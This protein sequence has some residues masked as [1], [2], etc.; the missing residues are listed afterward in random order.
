MLTALEALS[1]APEQFTPELPH[2]LGLRSIYWQL[3]C[4]RSPTTSCATSWRGCGAMAVTIEDG[5]LSDAEAALRAAQEALRQALERG[6]T[7]EEIKK[8]TDELRAALDKF[9]Q[10]LAEQMRK[11]PQQLARP[12][13]PQHPHAAA[14]G[15]QE[16][17]RPARAA[18]ALGRQGR[19]A[20]GCSK[21]CSRCWKTCRWRGPA[22]RA[23]TTW[24][25]T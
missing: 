4:A 1:I 24:T 25:T 13:D 14:A 7:D 17:D 19:G 6:A 21:S 12:L 23:A 10:A 20:S 9:M 2:Y 22:S 16:H 8:L 5:K 11:N 15:S 18:R 3:D